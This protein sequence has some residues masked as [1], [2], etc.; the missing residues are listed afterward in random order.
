VDP[1]RS[2]SARDN[3]ARARFH[4]ARAFIPRSC[5]P[6]RS[7]SSA[8]PH[9]AASDHLRPRPTACGLGS[10]V[11]TLSGG[12][13]QFE[14][15]AR[16]LRGK[17]PAD[18][19]AADGKLRVLARLTAAFARLPSARFVARPVSGGLV[20]ATAFLAR[21]GA[22]DDPANRP[23]E[24]FLDFQADPGGV[25]IHGLTLAGLPD[26]VV[27]AVEHAPALRAALRRMVDE[28]RALAVGER[29][30]VDGRAFMASPAPTSPREA[31]VLVPAP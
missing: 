28:N 27:G 3:T 24:A 12:V 22:L 16:A 23:M 1:T 26:L 13:P 25:R 8:A 19:W 11:N 5:C 18:P 2:K 4:V 31:L 6:S 30:V 21:C 15:E 9:A 14:R 29:V 20:P 7:S 10:N 17:N